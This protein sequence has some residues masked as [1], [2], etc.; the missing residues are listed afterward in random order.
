MRDRQLFNRKLGKGGRRGGGERGRG[1]GEDRVIK[2][3]FQERQEEKAVHE[4]IHSQTC[5]HFLSCGSEEQG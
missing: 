2:G 1:R 5:S 4:S 3:P